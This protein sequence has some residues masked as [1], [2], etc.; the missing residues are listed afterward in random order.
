MADFG[1]LNFAVAFNPQ[2]AFPLDARYYFSTLADATT[3]AQS[4]VEVGSSDGTYF[5]G[6]NLVVVTATDAT[7]YVIQP[8]KT[9]KAVGTSVLGDGKSI[10][11][12]DGTVSIKGFAD[13][14]TNQQPR[15]NASGEIEWYTPD[16][17]TVAGLADTVGQHTQQI[18]NLTSDISSLSTNKADKDSVY[19]KTETDNQIKSAISSVYKPA[20]SIAFI[21]LPALTSDNEGKVYNITDEFTTTNNFVEG[22]GKKYSAGQNV[23]IIKDSEGVYKYDVLSGIVDLSNYSTTAEVQ[24]ALDNKVDKVEGSRL[25]TDAEASKLAGIE[26]NAQV[27]V[28]DG[29]NSSEFSI[30]ESKNLNIL[31]IPQ[32]KITNL[33][34]D[35]ESKVDKVEG[36]GLSTNDFTNTLL[37]KLNGITAGAQVNTIDEVKINGTLLSVVDKSVNIPGASADNL[38]VVKGSSADNGVTINEDY[39]MT[40]NNISTDKLVAGSDTLVWNGGDATL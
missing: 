28:I 38:G 33:I 24:A 40:V 2:T 32:S 6:E 14:T 37:D 36:K 8:D 7:L 39:S 3:A 25:I 11:V 17:S 22:A 20:G 34:S 15:K 5:I 29:V 9:L 26:A 31:A 18:E 23:V 4:A 13:A 27:N 1:T 19:T 16:T 30:D 12:S 21:D 35:L 10:V